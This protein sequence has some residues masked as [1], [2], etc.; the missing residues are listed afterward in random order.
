MLEIK[1]IHKHM[2]MQYLIVCFFQMMFVKYDQTNIL[3]ME[4]NMTMIETTTVK[5]TE[6]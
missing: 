5:H 2:I 4:L 1:C 6:E 3:L